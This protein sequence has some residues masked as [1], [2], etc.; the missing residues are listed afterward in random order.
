MEY[1][2]IVKQKDI[3]EQ[4]LL[5]VCKIKS[6][7]GNYSI[8]SQKQWIM[9]NLKDD[10]KHFLLYK[11]DVL[12][13]YLNLIDIQILINGNSLSVYGIGNVCSKESGNGFGSKILSRLN[14]FLRSVSMPG[15]LFCKQN[16]ISF[17]SKNGWTI[18]DC[19]NSNVLKNKEIKSMIFNFNDNVNKIEYTGRLF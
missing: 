15:Y 12:V 11:D 14:E 6:V 5:E 3:S 16:L 1:L 10:D 19:D 8:D 9:N 4:E 17:Y 13:A 2:D 18:L 7:F